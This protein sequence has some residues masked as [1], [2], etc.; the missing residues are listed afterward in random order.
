MIEGMMGVHS[1]CE[2]LITPAAKI[3]RQPRVPLRKC[4]ENV[5]IQS[6]LP[7]M[8]L[9]IQ[10]RPLDYQDVCSALRLQEFRSNILNVQTLCVGVVAVKSNYLPS[11]LMD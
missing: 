6:L 5:Q 11:A 10:S 7:V 8:F 1:I 9:S 2:A 3:T 4:E